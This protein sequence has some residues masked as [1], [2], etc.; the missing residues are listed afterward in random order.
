ML[1]DARFLLA[2]LAGDVATRPIVESLDAHGH[3]TVTTVSIARLWA[4][5]SSAGATPGERHA[6]RR[7]VDGLEVAP[8]DRATAVI[9]SEL[10]EAVADHEHRYVAAAA[11]RRGE[12]VLTDDADR[13]AGVDGL[14]VRRY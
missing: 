7:L 2:V 1:V 10:A 9:A 6:S 12:A 11:R 4:A 5:L 14:E 3:G 13:Y 8:I